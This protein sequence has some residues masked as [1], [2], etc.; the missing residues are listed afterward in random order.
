MDVEPPDINSIKEA[1]LIYFHIR[2][3]Y[4]KTGSFHVEITTNLNITQDVGKLKKQVEGYVTQCLDA[5]NKFDEIKCKTGSERMH[6]LL[7]RQIINPTLK[8]E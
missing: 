2:D 7:L 5:M 8:Q 1:G 3:I 6:Y 4:A